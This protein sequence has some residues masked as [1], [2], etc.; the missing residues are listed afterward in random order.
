MKTL[1]KN[2]KI[3]ALLTLALSVTFFYFLYQFIE[4]KQFNYVIIGSSMFGAALFLLG[5]TLGYKDKMISEKMS[6]GFRYHLITYVIVNATRIIT[7]LV[8]IGFTTQNILAILSTLFF[9]GLGLAVHYF[10]GKKRKNTIK[11][12]IN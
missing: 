10:L 11:Q 9:W 5:F 1:S 2:Q 12:T 8:F 3:F 7:S 4:S 6:L